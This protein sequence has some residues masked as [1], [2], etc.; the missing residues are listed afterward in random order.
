MEMFLDRELVTMK[1]H[2]SLEM[3]I[4]VPVDAQLTS[5]LKEGKT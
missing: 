2:I 3:L 5:V 1:K 4:N